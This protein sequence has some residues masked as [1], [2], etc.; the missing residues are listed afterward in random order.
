MPYG[1]N[2]QPTEDEPLTDEEREQRVK[3]VQREQEERL[4]RAIGDEFFEFLAEYDDDLN[5]W[6]RRLRQDR[7]VLTQD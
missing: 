6:L 1:P 3:E 5:E 7:D 2:R 4:R